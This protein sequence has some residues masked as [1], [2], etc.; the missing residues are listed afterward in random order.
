MFSIG[1]YTPDIVVWQ[2]SPKLP[3]AQRN[4][5]TKMAFTICPGLY[6]V[7][8]SKGLWR[9]GDFYLLSLPPKK[10]QAPQWGFISLSRLFCPRN[11]LVALGN[12]F[13]FC[14]NKCCAMGICADRSFINT[15]LST[16]IFFASSAGHIFNVCMLQIRSKLYMGGI[17]I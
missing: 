11:V 8:A 13:T 10:T 7:E 17:K 9:E 16:S 1:V 3:G 14:A 6:A 5:S 2:P 12:S 15:S 4:S